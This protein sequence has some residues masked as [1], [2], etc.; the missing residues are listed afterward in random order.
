MVMNSAALRF[1]PSEDLQAE[2]DGAHRNL[3][4]QAATSEGAKR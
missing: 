4:D 1:V 3:C 2:G